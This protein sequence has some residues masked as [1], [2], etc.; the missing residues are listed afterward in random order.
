MTST[1]PAAPALTPLQ[2]YQAMSTGDL[3]AELIDTAR[4]A[5]TSGQY[6][7]VIA[8]AAT[9][10]QHRAGRTTSIGG[11]DTRDAAEVLAE[12]VD[13][14]GG[15]LSISTDT[16]RRALGTRRLSA[17]HRRNVDPE[18]DHRVPTHEESLTDVGLRV[19]PGPALPAGMLRVV[20]YLDGQSVGA[21]LSALTAGEDVEDLAAELLATTRR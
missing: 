16:V 8:P 7:D 18:G 14:A 10:L 2:R 6:S 15:Y 20:L 13:G 9:V 1:T 4:T 12:Q 11:R 5:L 21:L 19:Y 3:L 17:L